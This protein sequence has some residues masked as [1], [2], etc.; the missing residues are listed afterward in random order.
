MDLRD[1]VPWWGKI[2]LK[3]ILSR[4]NISY[5]TW[6]K[7]RIF[8]HGLMDDPAY[9]YNTFKRHYDS[10]EFLNKGNKFTML[11][12]GPGDSLASGIIASYHGAAKSLLV[13]KSD[14]AIQNETN[15]E[16]LLQYL[17]SELKMNE[18]ARTGESIDK[19]MARWNI[20]YLTDGL[21]SLKSIRDNSIDY[22]WSQS[23]L[24]HIR[25]SEFSSYIREFRRIIKN[26]GISVHG[27]DLKD[28]L[29]YA[30]NN[31]RF[32][33]KTWE[34][35][36]MAK[37][38]FYTNRILFTEMMA[39]IKE[40]GFGITVKNIKKWDKIPTQRDKLDRMYRNLPEDEL[41]ISDFDLI[42]K[43]V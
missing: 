23:V 33:E 43:P 9:A 41:K 35:D 5:K 11:E 2:A 3:V 42:L 14:D 37:S 15:Y 12:L 4:L 38:G 39:I 20:E 7:L 8:R 10:A 19:I 36:F 1:K 29:S 13:D 18:T 16:D 24:E 30:H 22:L 40:N 32:S 25:K 21:E 26:E 31:L 28:H 17:N 27:V 6:Q 34:S